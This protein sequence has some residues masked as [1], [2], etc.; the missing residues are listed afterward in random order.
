MY[1]M[2]HG[3]LYTV[4]TINITTNYFSSSRRFSSASSFLRSRSAAN[5][6]WAI[7]RFLS[8]SLCATELSLM[9][10]VLSKVIYMK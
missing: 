2:L 10:F 5:V 1:E 9:C 6:S 8:N 4:V 3:V 7:R